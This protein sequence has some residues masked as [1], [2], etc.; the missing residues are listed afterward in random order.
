M[1]AIRMMG[2]IAGKFQSTTKVCGLV[3]GR[4]D[5]GQRLGRVD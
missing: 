5:L 4:N 2:G 1:A 3:N